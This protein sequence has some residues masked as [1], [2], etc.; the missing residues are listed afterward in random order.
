M[1]A[2]TEETVKQHLKVSSTMWDIVDKFFD[3]VKA[4]TREGY[5]LIQTYSIKAAHPVLPYVLHFL[6]MM[7]AM[8]NGAKTR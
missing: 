5:A 4:L 8:A 6:A 1:S 7:R 2:A 3:P